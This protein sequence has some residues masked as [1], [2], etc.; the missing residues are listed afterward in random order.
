MAQARRR[1]A[2]VAIFLALILV[3]TLLGC[4]GDDDAS[5]PPAPGP[6]AASRPEDFPTGRGMTLR[7]L[8][9]EVGE[10]PVLSSTVRHLRQGRNR[11]GFALF[12][13]ARKPITGAQA[14]VY[15][16]RA[17]GR[18]VRGPYP[19]RTESLRVDSRFLSRTSASDPDAAKSVYVARVPFRVRGNHVVMALA[20]LDGRLVASSPATVEVEGR[21][22]GP[23]AVGE[24]AIRVSTPTAAD[25]AGDLSKIDTRSPPAASLH[26]VDFADVVGR[27]PVVLVFATPQLCQS[28]VC[29]PVVDV[30]AQLQARYGERVAFVHMEIYEDNDV[31]KGYRPQVTAW[32]LRS[33]PWTFVIDRSGTVAARFEGAASLAEVEKAVERVAGS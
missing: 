20:R 14:A 27:K 3:P 28:R 4:G 32:R 13:V 7:E 23:P 2:P 15:V 22:D 16:A 12:D 33:E 31:R 24:P 26:E 18:P 25:V 17:P 9:D 29:G 10:G 30:A 5:S 11:V 19:A 8:R 21:W 1:L 6:Q